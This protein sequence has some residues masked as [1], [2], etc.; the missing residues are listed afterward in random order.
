LTLHRWG[1]TS[2]PTKPGAIRSTISL[3]ANGACALADGPRAPLFTELPTETV[4]KI[5]IGVK[6]QPDESVNPLPPNF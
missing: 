4:W 5:R 3:A 2:A 6:L 1:A